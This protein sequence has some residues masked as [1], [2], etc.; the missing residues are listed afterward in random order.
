MFA[1]HILGSLRSP[2]L[3]GCNY[4]CEMTTKGNLVRT[5]KEKQRAREKA[6]IFSENTNH[7][8]INRDSNRVTGGKDEHGIHN[9]GKMI[10]AELC[11]Q[12][13]VRNVKHVSDETGYLAEKNSKC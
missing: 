6:S 11:S 9:E 4:Y 8:N 1:W 7:A 5:G 12:P 3:G 13:V 2:V 10:L